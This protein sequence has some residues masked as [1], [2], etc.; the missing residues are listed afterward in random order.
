MKHLLALLIILLMARL[1][2]P[3]EIKLTEPL[4]EE[5]PTWENAIEG[6]NSEEEIREAYPLLDDP[7][8]LEFLLRL[9][10]ERREARDS[11]QVDEDAPMSDSTEAAPHTVGSIPPPSGFVRTETSG[12]GT[13]LRQLPLKPRESKVH[14]YDGTV[15]YWQGGAYA[16]VD[17]E[18]GKSDLQQ[19]ADACIRLRAEYLWRSKKYSDIHFNFTSGFR[20][21]YSKWADGYRIS[22]SGNKAEW[23]KAG[24]PDY[25]YNAF[26]KYLDM[27]FSYAGTLSLSKELRTTTLADVRIGDVFIVGGSPGHAMI[28]VDLA[29]DDSGRSAIMVAQSYMPAQDIHIVTNL[30]D[31][32]VSPWYVFDENTQTFRFPEW[33]FFSDQVKRF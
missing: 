9:F 5:H 14:L 20:A 2:G 30:N 10:R 11:I 32:S 17:M 13:Y 19:C 12:F 26:R 31:E 1:C 28:I 3:R 15:K 4:S 25:G 18:I 8:R 22:V 29:R 6:Y 7:E 16:V 21:D 23:Y 33:T 24:D 27:V